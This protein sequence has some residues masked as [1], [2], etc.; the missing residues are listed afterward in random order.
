M[1]ATTTASAAR[2]RYASAY[3]W[4]SSRLRPYILFP[5]L[6]LLGLAMVYPV[7]MVVYGSFKGGPPGEDAPFTLDGYTRVW[8]QASTIKALIVTFGLA[9]PRM[10]TGVIFAVLATW[11]ITRT[12][13]PL[14]GVFE[15]LMW[16]RVFL[17]VLPMLVA[18]I[19]IGS[20]RMGLVNQFLMNTFGFSSAPLDIQSYWGIIFLSLMT[21][22]SFFFMFMAPAFR[23][24]DASL[25][26]SSRVSGASNLTTLWRITVPI[27][28]PAILGVTLLVFLFVL[29]SYETELFLLGPKGVYVFTTY[30]WMMM[31]KIP[32]DY[33]AA[34]ALS[35]AF[36]VFVAAVVLIQFKVLGGKQY[37]TV[38]G[39][40]FGV[41]LIDLGAW[42]WVTFGL[43]A[44]W[45]L[46]GLLF[47]M[48]VLI[49][50]T[51]LNTYGLFDSGLT[52]E[53]WRE[54]LGHYAV[55]RSIKNTLWLGLM[56]ATLG[57]VVYALMSYASLRTRLKGRQGIE[58]LS[59][60]PRMAP[61]IVMAVGIFW[62][63]IGG[64]GALK[65]LYGTIFLMALIVVIEGTPQ[66]M[67]MM[68]GGMVQLSAE[69]EEAARVSGASWLGTMRKVVIPLLAPTL[70]NAWLLKFLSATRALVIFLFIYKSQSK[71]LSI[72]IFQRMLGGEPQQAA[73]LGVI[74][75]A[76]SMVI[77]IFA[78]FIA[79]RQRRVMESTVAI[80]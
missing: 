7:F 24:M 56:A 72:D 45:T 21:S 64:I 74:L 36:M 31:G 14:R 3:E 54:A 78:R 16:L 9:I 66:G 29:S 20:G 4:L 18:W 53:H 73:V 13:T 42:K 70:L 38:S 76:I 68:N 2:G 33:T 5:F 59:W 52:L 15:Q 71:V 47:P 63:I 28:M 55:I 35:S 22:G 32:T 37:V 27:M 19:I 40:G 49:Y 26:E 57:T 11:I 23:N 6:G 17:P 41:R 51:F 80:G 8:T 10:A 39:R 65:A 58:I 62:A 48:V 77:A 46:V 50:G 12:N 34:M 79:S 25:E 44:S 75:T 61:G 67:R 1:G 30:I 69:L 60:V 43:L